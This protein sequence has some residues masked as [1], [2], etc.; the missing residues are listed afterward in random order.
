MSNKPL[1]KYRRN[2]IAKGSISVY[3]KFFQQHL[4]L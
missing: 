1:V 3:F 2:Q 4:E